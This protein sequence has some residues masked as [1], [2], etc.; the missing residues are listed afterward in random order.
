VAPAGFH[1]VYN[2]SNKSEWLTAYG[3]RTYTFHREDLESDDH[4]RRE[5][6]ESDD[7]NR[8]GPFV[9]KSGSIGSSCYASAEGDP[10]A[11]G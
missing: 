1:D 6:L 11:C 4:N 5:D 3:K 9:W 7:H 8:T 10:P 2:Q